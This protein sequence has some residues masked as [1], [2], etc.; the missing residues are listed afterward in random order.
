MIFKTI[1]DN[2]SL[3]GQRI[4][5]K[6]T[7]RKIAQEEATKQ[8]EIQK[9]Q[10]ELNSAMN[11]NTNKV[12]V[13]GQMVWQTDDSAITDARND[14][15]D[16]KAQDA[17]DKLQDQIDELDKASD[18]LDKQKDALQDQIDSLND[19]LDKIT[20][21]IEKQIDELQKYKDRWA[22]IPD[23]FTYVQNQMIA[24]MMLGQD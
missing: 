24:S 11:Q 8:L 14:L 21:G 5:S 12:Y 9:K 19:E 4:V 22:E 1:D 13:N 3:S 20:E 16:A 15:E 23:Q 18:A 2:D 7:A 10:Y 17:T 6:F